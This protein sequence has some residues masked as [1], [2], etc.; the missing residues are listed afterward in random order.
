MRFLVDEIG[1][2]EGFVILGVVWSVPTFL[3]CFFFLG[4]RR[5]RQKPAEATI[6]DAHEPSAVVELPGMTMQEA[7]RSVALWRV[8]LSTSI[9]MAIASVFVVHV[10]PMLTEM[11][12][13][14]SD[15]ALLTSLY[16]VAGVVGK[17]LT[18][19]MM[20]H[21]DGG[22][23]GAW[24]NAATAMALIFMLDPFRTE[25]AIVA[26]LIVVGYAN[27]TKLQICVYLT[28]SLAGLRSYG[29]I[30]GAI[31]SAIALAGGLGT[32]LA[33]VIYDRFGSYQAMIIAF[34]PASLLAAALIFRINTRR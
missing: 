16:G 32:L 30:F 24:T 29:K 8:G 5:G 12:V 1:W 31:S 6:A 26:T 23:I 28:G 19:W 4:E 17:L 2:R 34:I 9:M 20:E 14:R 3:L 33:G 27:G 21:I 7:A 22:L 10:V 11:G 15:A 18:G 25:L 13:S